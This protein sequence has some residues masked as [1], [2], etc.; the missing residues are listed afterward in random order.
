MGLKHLIAIEKWTCLL[1]LVLLGGAMLL[2]SRHAAFS[3]AV[4]AALTALNAAVIRRV[5]EKLGALLQARPALTILL[6]NI[7]MGVLIVLIFLALRFLHLD[8]L[9][10][11][12]GISTLPAAIVIVVIQHALTP[13]PSTPHEEGETHG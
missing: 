1:G 9:P 2:L 7:K 6:F 5:A 4:G 3:L 13:P 12:V 10:F 8:A 11:I